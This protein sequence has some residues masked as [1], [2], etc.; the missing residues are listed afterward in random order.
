MVQV[1]ARRSNQPTN[2]PP[3]PPLIVVLC[4]SM[5]C[6]TWQ[7]MWTLT[8]SMTWTMTHLVTQLWMLRTPRTLHRQQTLLKPLHPSLVRR[9]APRMSHLDLPS[10]SALSHG[11]HYWWF[12][13]GEAAPKRSYTLESIAVAA[14][15][16]YGLNFL[17]GSRKNS[18]LAHAW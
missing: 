10:P 15:V 12:C 18:S 3:C 5:L 2:Q 9:V 8:R 4:H 14:L 13:T 16:L 6:C 11:Y 17:Y 1:R 7:T